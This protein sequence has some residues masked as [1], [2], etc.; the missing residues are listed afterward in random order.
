MIRIMQHYV[1]NGTVK[2][3]CWYSVDSR[4]KC[5]IIYAADYSR[6]LGKIFPA[7]YENET[8]A[9]SDYF[10]EGRVVIFEN[11]PMYKTVLE[12]VQ[13]YELKKKIA[14]AKKVQK[15]P[16]RFSYCIEEYRQYFN[17]GAA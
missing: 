13:K 5:V 4:R 1:T 3:K 10:D 14:F 9:M 17:L 8:D 15:N 11:H 12:A 2:A 7:E 16:V 6:S